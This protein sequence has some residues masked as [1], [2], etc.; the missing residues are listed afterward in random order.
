MGPRGEFQVRL[1]PSD[2]TRLARIRIEALRDGN[3]IGSGATPPLR[4][5]AQG[6]QLRAVLMHRRDTL[7]PAPVTWATAR[8]GHLVPAGLE[9]AFALT[10]PS[11]TRE[12]RPPDGYYLSGHARYADFTVAVPREFDDESAVVTLDGAWLF[13]RGPRALLYTGQMETT[14]ADVPIPAPRQ[15]LVGASVAPFVTGVGGL[16]IGGR[17][18]STGAPSARVDRVNGIDYRRAPLSSVFA[19]PAPPPLAAARARPEIVALEMPA[20]GN[21]RWLL[22]GGQGPGDPLLELYDERVGGVALATGDASVDR[23]VE[24]GA[25]C[26]QIEN[27]VCTRV[28]VVG[29]RS[30][31]GDTGS[32]LDDLLLDATCALRGGAG[33][34]LVLARGQWLSRPRWG[35][36]VALAEGGRVLVA[37]GSDAAGPVGEV[38]TV[39]VSDPN[40]PRLGRI[41]GILPYA[42]PA[43]LALTNGSVMV[44]GGRN[45]DGSGRTEIWFYRY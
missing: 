39:D 36:R 21:A 7:I 26:V 32:P 43:L 24:V 25:T 42:D 33:C 17:D 41:V 30:S 6:G 44:A 34:T 15:A 3:V 12:D 4:W 40:A 13:V 38:E 16:L 29:G 11:G 37:G 5:Q 14:R 19:D 2:P 9:F 8:S 23:R 1:T 28:L 31:S 35:A 45:P 20:M 10:L 22:A 27:D 18:A